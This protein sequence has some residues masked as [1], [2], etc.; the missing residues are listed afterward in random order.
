ME[1]LNFNP[2]NFFLVF[3]LLVIVSILL[4]LL[5]REF[6]CWYWKI[7]KRISM[8][9][10]Q[11][12]LLEKILAH[13]KSTSPNQSDTDMHVSETISINDQ[14]TDFNR[15]IYDIL[16]SLEQKEADKFIKH[17]LRP[18]EKIVIN[19]TTREINRFSI[20]EWTEICAKFED[21]KWSIIWERKLSSV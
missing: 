14:M 18:G 1:D 9:E 5:F 2:A 6:F 7:N 13:L 8:T 10:R 11:V 16:S 19:K 20:K 4:F 12:V 15:D 3:L 21:H 17:G